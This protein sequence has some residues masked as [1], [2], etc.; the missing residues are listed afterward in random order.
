[1]DHQAPRITT[2]HLADGSVWLVQ[3]EGDHDASTVADLDA[4]LRPLLEGGEAVV[5]DLSRASFAESAILGSLIMAA[6]RGERHGFAVVAPPGS[7]AARLLDATGARAF[8]AVYPT[9]AA[10]ITASRPTQLA[11]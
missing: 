1:V 4:K 3:V 2:T 7:A 8:F 11:G 10:A 9:R 5:V 6:K